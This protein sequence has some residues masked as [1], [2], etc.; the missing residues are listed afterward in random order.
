MKIQ[1]KSLRAVNIGPLKDVTLD[2]TD[3]SGQPRQNTLIGGANGNGKTTVLELIF[4]LL[5]L[6][7]PYPNSSSLKSSIFQNGNTNDAPYAHLILT[8]DAATFTIFYGNPPGNIKL[9][10]ALSDHNIEVFFVANSYNRL[11]GTLTSGTS[12]TAFQ[13]IQHI[14]AS[15]KELKI[16]FDNANISLS[17]VI[18]PSVLFFPHV[19]N[20][21]PSQGKSVIREDTLYRWT[22]RYQTIR[23]FA[24]SL[25]SYLIWLEYSD[26]EEFQ[27][28]ANFLS[29]HIDG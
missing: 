26:I 4:G 12:L 8:I 25:N 23:S 17:T 20:I 1:I 29:R 9:A 19:R 3:P 7:N 21:I 24:G 13:E 27:Q 14:I 18:V 10:P 6:I 28:V 22:Y 11:N 2:F 15:Q 5:N 16:A